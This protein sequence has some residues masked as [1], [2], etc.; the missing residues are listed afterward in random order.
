MN[1][2]IRDRITTDSVATLGSVSLLGESAVDITPSSAGTPIP[3]WGYV[4]PG[5]TPAQLAD[6]T[7]QASQGMARSTGWSPT[8]APARARSAS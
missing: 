1:K 5:R 6:I 7:D 2:E 8:S 4:P 3:E